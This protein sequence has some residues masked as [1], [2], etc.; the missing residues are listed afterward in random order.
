[1]LLEMLS[2]RVWHVEDYVI[3]SVEDECAGD[4]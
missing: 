3:S 2:I 4:D 1:M